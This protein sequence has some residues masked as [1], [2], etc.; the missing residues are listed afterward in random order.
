[1]PV[2]RNRS[3][4]KRSAACVI[5]TLRDPFL[6]S[7]RCFFYRTAAR[8]QRPQCEKRMKPLRSCVFWEPRLRKLNIGLLGYCC[9]PCAKLVRYCAKLLRCCVKLASVT[10]TCATSLWDEESLL[11]CTDTGC[12]WAC[13]LGR[14]DGFHVKRTATTPIDVLCTNCCVLLC[15]C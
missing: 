13:A 7:P 15:C 6:N 8:N 1:M 9:P 3:V 11:Y 5:A 4:H 10:V 2:V 12:R 14:N